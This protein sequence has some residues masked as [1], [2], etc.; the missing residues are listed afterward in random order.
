MH[1]SNKIEPEVAG[2]HS[3]GETGGIKGDDFR[4]PTASEFFP[5][6]LKANFQ[7]VRYPAKTSEG[8]TL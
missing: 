1:I 3:A 8:A 2:G 7:L 6:V 5:K 4:L